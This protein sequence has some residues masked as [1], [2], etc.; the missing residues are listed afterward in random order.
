MRVTVKSSV[1]RSG[2]LLL[3]LGMVLALLFLA[4]ADGQAAGGGISEIR[5]KYVPY[6]PGTD[7]SGTGWNW[8]ASTKTLT[9]SG[10]VDGRINFTGEDEIKIRVD[11]NGSTNSIGYS[12]GSLDISGSG[13]LTINGTMAG[14]S[15]KNLVI[16]SA[17]ID[18]G[19]SNEWERAIYV[20]ENVDIKGG[21]LILRETSRGGVG[22]FAL[23]GNINI[24]GSA[25]VRTA[26]PTYSIALCSDKGQ[27]TVTDGAVVEVASA[28]HSA[29]YS[30]NITISGGT[31]TARSSSS[32]GAVS[33]ENLNI[34]G[35]SLTTG[36]TDA[37]PVN[38]HVNANLTV[39]GAGSTVTLN[40]NLGSHSILGSKGDLTV[41]DGTVTIT[42]TI[43]GTPIITGGT[44]SINGAPAITNFIIVNSGTVNPVSAMPG[45]TITITAEAAPAGKYFKEWEITP[46]VTFVENTDA[47]DTVAKFTMPAAAVTATAVYEDTSA[48]GYSGE[49]SE[50]DISQLDKTPISGSKWEYSGTIETP[51]R[52]LTLKS[53]GIT[54]TG[55]NNALTVKTPP[56]GNV[57]L[58]NVTI[59]SS[60]AQVF[61]CLGYD[62]DVVLFSGASADEK[63]AM[64]LEIRG[65]NRLLGNDILAATKEL[66]LTG[67]GKLDLESN[68][69]GLSSWG[70]CLIN[71]PALTAS[72]ASGKFPM[73]ML[74]GGS[75]DIQNGSLTLD[76]TTGNNYAAALEDGGYGTSLT[77][78]VS[79]GAK[80]TTIAGT[81]NTGDPS[82][83]FWFRAGTQNN[84]TVINNGGR[85]YIDGDVMGKAINNSG[86]FEITGAAASFEGEITKPTLPDVTINLENIDHDSQYYTVSSTAGKTTLSV[87]KPANFTLTGNNPEAVLKDTF[88]L[89]AYTF[90]DMTIARYE[91]AGYQIQITGVNKCGG[92]PY[93]GN[94]SGSNYLGTGTLEVNRIYGGNNYEWGFESADGVL[95]INGPSITVTGFPSAVRHLNMISGSL[96]ADGYIDNIQMSGGTA[97]IESNDENAWSV[98]HTGGSLTIKTNGYF[99]NDPTDTEPDISVVFAENGGTRVPDLYYWGHTGPINVTEPEIPTRGGYIFGGWYSDTESNNAVTFPD[100]ITADKTYYAK[101]GEVAAKYNLTVVSGS[102]SGDYTQ[103]ET[104]TITANTPPSEQQFK[105][106]EITPAVTFVEGTSK[107]DATARFIMLAEMVTAT[108]TYQDIPE[109]IYSITVQNDGNG[110]ANA[111]VNA[112]A[113]GTEVT[114]TATAN[115]SYRFKEWQVVSDN[116]EIADDKFTMPSGAVTIRAIFEEVEVEGCF[117]ATAAFG[118]K[119]TGP[120]TLLRH[121]RD[122]YLL[123]GRWGTEFVNSYYRFSPP[124]ANIIAGSE[125]LR[126]LTRLLLAP[127]IIL[128]YMLFNPLWIFIIMGL[129]LLIC[130]QRYSLMLQNA[131][132]LLKR[133]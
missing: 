117:I 85:V 44:V 58:D 86:T 114:L 97:V 77:V 78:T 99:Y 64:S 69:N 109:N 116:V 89:S 57:I 28:E 118:S 14:I 132:P 112:A 46:A 81:N 79:S 102:G 51:C 15:A 59:T 98:V 7:Q 92:T 11:G 38:G 88:E 113:Q 75:L 55:T 31:V 52:V 5:I 23:N 125:P 101:W 18:V 106:W 68:G 74:G 76:N 40:G 30:K 8:T 37:S 104:V 131:R 111:D 13:T 39:S 123:T 36:D 21:T 29:I 24:G 61:S 100:T 122:D 4:V 6:N 54:L 133:R 12:D 10:A 35:G 53:G 9:I 48:L 103:G 22:I 90:A 63:V 56:A 66:S 42:G 87:T 94:V 115:P 17:T 126:L 72:A 34:T 50:I 95:T 3:G 71:G 70:D 45:T 91:I 80:F 27:I 73:R 127:V 110:I 105:E 25:N 108:A 47:T 93:A 26:S 84:T 82:R 128:V 96:R 83:D 124:I 19:A 49:E 32:N 130:L 1:R 60:G 65:N 107:T 121:F 67:T 41:T 62:G 20:Q 16:N 119:F 33:A 120:V 129:L 43:A 2:S